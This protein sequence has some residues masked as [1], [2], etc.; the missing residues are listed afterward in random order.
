MVASV[1]AVIVAILHLGFMVLESIL[2]T[3]PIGRKVFRLSQEKAAITRELA[4]NQGVYNGMLAVGIVWALAVGNSGALAFLLVFVVIVGIYGA[5]TVSPAIFVV[6]SLP[7]L[8][9]LGLQ[10]FGW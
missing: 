10:R 1:A 7:A 3:Q 8:I 6:Q 9:A 4:S 2:W 5:L